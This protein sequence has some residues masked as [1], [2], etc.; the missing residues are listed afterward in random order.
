[1]PAF[2]LKM[3]SPSG[4]II[5]K[6]LIADTKTALKQSM[7]SDGNFVINI[8]RTEGLGTHSTTEYLLKT[9]A[10]PGK[11]GVIL[12]QRSV[13]FDHIWQMSEKAGV[14][15]ILTR[16]NR[17]FVLRSGSYNRAPIKLGTR[18]ILHTHPTNELGLNSLHPSSAD[19]NVLNFYWSENPTLSRPV[20]QILT[21]QAE[22]TRFYAT[23]FEQLTSDLRIKP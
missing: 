1:M 9:G 10:I 14:E 4:R 17:R 16:E 15:Y 6:T 23:G 3:A 18:P 8:S 11:E 19:I 5:E 7:E 20:S 13:P 21:G 2:R 22:P 12:N